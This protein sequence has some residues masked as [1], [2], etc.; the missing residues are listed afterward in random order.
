MFDKIRKL[1]NKTPVVRKIAFIDGDQSIPLALAAYHKY[2]ANT[3][4]ETHLIRA[5]PQGDNPPKTLRTDRSKDINKIYL[6][7]FSVGKEVTDK[8]I[9]G[10]IQKAIHDGFTHITV[11]SSDY[12]FIDIFKMAVQ[13]NPE[14]A[15][16]TFQMVVPFAVGKKLHDAGTQVANINII[17]MREK[18][19]A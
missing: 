10:M 14:A 7:G 15:N 9:A 18:Q 19:H 12:D 5:M 4:T 1:F 8:Y 17:K 13:I 3:G 2:V 11:I 6:R 16:F